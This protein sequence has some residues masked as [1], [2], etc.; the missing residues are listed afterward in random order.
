LGAAKGLSVGSSSSAPARAD[1][2]VAV[3]GTLAAPDVAPGRRRDRPMPASAPCCSSG[4]RLL[5][6]WGEP[7]RLAKEPRRT[8]GGHVQRG[9]VFGGTRRPVA[10]IVAAVSQSSGPERGTGSFVI[11]ISFG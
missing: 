11:A 3:A 6:R 9:D 2:Q 10:A 4:S 1:R 8:A 5:R 7:R